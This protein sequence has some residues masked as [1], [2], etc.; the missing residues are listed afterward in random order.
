MSARP[1]QPTSSST[2]KVNSLAQMQAATTVH[3]GAGV[4]TRPAERSSAVS[5]G[6]KKASTQSEVN[7]FRERIDRSKSRALFGRTAEGGCPQV[8]C[9]YWMPKSDCWKVRARS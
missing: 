4:P 5:S 6:H 8:D 7:V 3:V 1:R 2:G 9:G